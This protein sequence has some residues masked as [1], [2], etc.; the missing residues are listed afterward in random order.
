MTT[1]SC[2]GR[3]SWKK[4]WWE[5]ARLQCRPP[6]STNESLLAVC[7]GAPVSAFAYS[8][9]GATLT[10]AGSLAFW[11]AAL[12]LVAAL[13]LP[14]LVPGLRASLRHIAAGS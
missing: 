3:N 8:A 14:C 9:F 7:L 5:L 11:I 13:V 1:H 6:T 10:E 4:K 2:I 12:A